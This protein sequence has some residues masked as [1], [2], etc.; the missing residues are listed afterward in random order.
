MNAF[1]LFLQAMLSSARMLMH[2]NRLA[3]VMQMSTNS[4]LGVFHFTHVSVPAL[5]LTI[6]R[7]QIKITS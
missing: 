5:H 7:Y 3:L 4:T 2:C 1:V 6:Y